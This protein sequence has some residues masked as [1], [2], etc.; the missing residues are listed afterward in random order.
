M[1]PRLC[2]GEL[3]WV[4]PSIQSKTS[5][6]AAVNFKKNWLTSVSSRL[7]PAIWSR[8]TGQRIPCFDRCQLI[9]T[10]MSNIKDA[11]CK[12]AWNWSHWH[13]W[14]G[15]RTYV[16]TVDGHDYKTKISRIDGLPYF[17]KDSAYYYYYA[18]VLRISR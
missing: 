5:T 11:C 13:T 3:T 9:K 16:R 8:G 2:L 14:R 4:D 10:W 6:W 12:L 17:L 15:G 1:K 7:E 18:Y